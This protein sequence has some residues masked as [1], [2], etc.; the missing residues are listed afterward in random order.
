M[1]LYRIFL[2]LPFMELLFQKGNGTIHQR[3]KDC[4]ND[5][6]KQHHAHGE[7]LRGIDNQ[8]TQT[9]LRYQKF[10]DNDPDKG[11]TDIDFQRIE[12]AGDIRRENHFREHLPFCAAENANQL[13]LVFI[14]LQKA[15]QD[16]KNRHDNR[17]EQGNDDDRG[18]IIP[19]PDD[20]DG[21]EGGFRQRIEDNE[22][23]FCHI[24]DKAVPPEQ[25]CRQRAE[26]RSQ[27]K[28]DHRFPEGCAD[29]Q[30][31]RAVPYHFY[32]CGE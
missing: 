14:Y 5:N 13:N 9:I 28:A 4:Q 15:V 12:D 31:K 17:G 2:S 18:L 16:G 6:R 22:I 1:F 3:G 19:E 26:Q 24:G 8:K 27:K 32:G 29:M 7:G 11:K 25:H 23:R 21:G 30:E 20:D 10:P